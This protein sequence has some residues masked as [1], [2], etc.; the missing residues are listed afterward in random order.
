MVIYLHGGKMMNRTVESGKTLLV[1]GP[2]SLSVVSGVVEVFGF[3]LRNM[4]D[5]VVREGK[6]LP[7]AVK[8]KTTFE[9]SLGEDA[10]IEEVDGD[11]I[12]SSW[13][14]AV[15]ELLDP[16]AK[17]FTV[18]V[19]GTVDSGKTSFCTFMINKLLNEQQKIAIL[20]GD[21]GQSDVGPP[22]TI[23]YALVT[24]PV[25]DLFTLQAKNGFFVGSTSPSG[26]IDKV[27]EG[28]ASLKQKILS[29]NPDVVVINTDGWVEGEDAVNYKSQLVE[30][31]NPDIVFCIQQKDELTSLLNTLEKSRR[32]VV[33]SP[34]DIKQRSQEKRRDSRERGYMKYLRDAK[35]RCIPL[36]WLTIEEN[37]FI[38]L[39]GN[40]GNM[41]Q[42]REIYELIGM[43]PLNLSELG[44]KICIVIGKRHWIN[45]DSIKKVEEITKKKVVVVHKGEE[46]GLL[47]ALYD[48]E[49]KFLGI[50]SL[51]EI[52]YARKTMKIY[53]PVSQRISIVTMGRVKLDENLKEIPISTEENQL[54]FTAFK[55]LF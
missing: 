20:D 29:S 8:E 42:A 25:M 37:E 34:V 51:R 10:N 35:V 13:V 49:R 32:V 33:D 14:M 28:L 30:K 9:I 47:M 27:M 2:A 36:S 44:D 31:A 4:R 55:N 21:I 41:R 6:R 48:A 23:S 3:V 53:T 19:L 16:E 40:R 26:C 54:S 24:K 12:P 39:G 18:M 5:I 46:E 38:G 17:P 11:T 50:G 7:F 45:L 15:E 43:K 1:D 52:D 22:C